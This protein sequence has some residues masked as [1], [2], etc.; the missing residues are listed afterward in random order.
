MSDMIETEQPSLRRTLR[1]TAENY[2]HT[3]S[4]ALVRRVA[5]SEVLITDWSRLD[6]DTF[7]LFAQFP[8]AHSF[9]STVGGVHDPLIVAEAARQ[10]TFV[11][12][13]AALSVPLHSN[14]VMNDFS[15]RIHPAAMLAGAAP[16]ELAVLLTCVEPRYRGGVL[17]SMG[18]RLVFYRDGVAAAEVTASLTCMPS[19][20][21]RRLREGRRRRPLQEQGSSSRLLPAAVIPALV[22]RDRAEDVVLAATADRRGYLLRSDQNHPV[23]FDHPTDHVSGMVLMEGMRQAAQLVRQPYRVLPIGLSAEF[24]RFVEFDS[25]CRIEA[26]ALAADADE[27]VSVEIRIEQDGELA[28]RATVLTKVLD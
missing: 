12:C 19:R 22:G 9:Y 24:D 28:A 18:V 11:V 21:Y 15:Y 3:V 13:H 14:F 25:D 26:S 16:T 8:R 27:D 1:G 17:G 6:T 20:V 2:E 23:L 4:R 7:L 10:A 5:I